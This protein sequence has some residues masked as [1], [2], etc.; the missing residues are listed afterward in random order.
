MHSKLCVTS[1]VFV[2]HSFRFSF[3]CFPYQNGALKH[4]G[5][6]MP[7]ITRQW[8]AEMTGCEY[9][10]TMEHRGRKNG[11]SK[12]SVAIK[13]SDFFCAFYHFMHFVWLFL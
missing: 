7:V 12:V 1:S 13:I 8:I 10:V 5:P 6:A 9:I 4:H 2:E 11:T 3:A